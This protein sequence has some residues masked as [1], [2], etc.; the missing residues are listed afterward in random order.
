MDATQM[1]SK[2]SNA[3]SPDLR[4]AI[5]P[6]YIR[7]PLPRQD[8]SPHQITPSHHHHP[9]AADGIVG[10]SEA[11]PVEGV[12]VNDDGLPLQHTLPPQPFFASDGIVAGPLEAEVEEGVDD[13]EL[14]VEGYLELL[15]QVCCMCVRRNA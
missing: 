7:H 13:N 10:P 9:S 8:T 2:V 5:E 11:G 1:P 4:L 12:G 3:S 14:D 6:Q 15:R